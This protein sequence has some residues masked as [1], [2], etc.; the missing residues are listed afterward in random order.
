MR[1]AGGIG[2]GSELGMP[3]SLYQT[4]HS[5]TNDEVTSPSLTWTW[6]RHPLLTV[7]LLCYIQS[8]CAQL[9]VASPSLSMWWAQHPHLTT[10][11]YA[12]FYQH[13][14]GGGTLGSPISLLIYCAIFS[15]A[16]H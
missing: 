14:G 6:L 8:C 15:A 16:V 7:S 11:C 4:M 5:S 13:K 2:P 12:L 10:Q 3:F 9:E 1:N